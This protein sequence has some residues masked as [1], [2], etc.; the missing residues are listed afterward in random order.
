MLRIVGMLPRIMVRRWYLGR[1]PSR[2]AMAK[3]KIEITPPNLRCSI[4]GC[5]AVFLKEDGRLIIIGKKLSSEEARQLEGR[6]ADD[7]FA[8]EIEAEYFAKLRASGSP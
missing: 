7:E 5:K 4:G 6:I 3:I 1:Y 2:A 8:I